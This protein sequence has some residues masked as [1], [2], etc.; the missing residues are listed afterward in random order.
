VATEQAIS[1]SVHKALSLCLQKGDTEALADAFVEMYVLAQMGVG[2]VPYA[3]GVDELA[4]KNL[5]RLTGQ[6]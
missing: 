1:A 6:S 3:Q 2:T 5:L 4:L